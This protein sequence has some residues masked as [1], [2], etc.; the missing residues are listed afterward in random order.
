MKKPILTLILALVA[1]VGVKAQ[2]KIDSAIFSGAITCDTCKIFY[3]PSQYTGFNRSDTTKVLAYVCTDWNKAKFKW[4]HM[5]A[6][7]I[8]PDRRKTQHFCNYS[9]N[10]CIGYWCKAMISIGLT[11]VFKIEC[12]YEILSVR[13]YSSEEDFFIDKYKNI[14]LPH[15]ICI[16][17]SIN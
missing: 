2:S 5:Y 12:Q 16:V 8:S 13:N 9:R 15:R 1:I 7:S 3:I 17:I 4:M 11:P 10:S 14:F 6:V